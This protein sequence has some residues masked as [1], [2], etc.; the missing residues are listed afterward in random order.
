MAFPL[1]FSQFSQSDS[2]AGSKVTHFW[3]KD[4]EGKSGGELLRNI[5][6]AKKRNVWEGM[7]FPFCLKTLSYEA[8]ILQLW[9]K[10]P[11]ELQR[12]H[13]ANPIKLLN[14]PILK[15]TFWLVMPKY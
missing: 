13:S 12:N 2:F 8:A 11:R 15:P 5:L 10:K 1:P 3:S 6:L 7:P 14:N 9:E 4:Q